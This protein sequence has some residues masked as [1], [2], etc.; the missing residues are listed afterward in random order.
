MALLPQMTMLAALA[1][2][3]AFGLGFVIQGIALL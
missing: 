1:A 2:G 3:I